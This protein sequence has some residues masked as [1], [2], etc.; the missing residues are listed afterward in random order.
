[1]VNAVQISYKTAL[2]ETP[3]KSNNFG[4]PFDKIPQVEEKVWARRSSHKLRPVDKINIYMVC[5][6]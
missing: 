5:D 3:K 6:K 1:M 4:K 2:G